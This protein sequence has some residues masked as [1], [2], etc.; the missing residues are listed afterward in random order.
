[1]AFIPVAV[2]PSPKLQAQP[3]IV[4]SGSVEPDPLKESATSVCVA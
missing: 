2:P 3:V 1:V 4:P